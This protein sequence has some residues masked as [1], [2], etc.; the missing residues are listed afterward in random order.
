MIPSYLHPEGALGAKLE[1][2]RVGSSP[3]P[4]F[5]NPRQ[6]PPPPPDLP[7]SPGKADLSLGC[8]TIPG[9][10]APPHLE[11]QLPTHQGGSELFPP[12][13]PGP[14]NRGRAEGAAAVCSGDRL[15][16]RRA[17]GLCRGWWGQDPCFTHLHG[18]LGPCGWCEVWGILG[19]QF[20][21]SNFGRNSRRSGD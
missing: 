13:L 1:G 15:G 8:N 21:L 3:P 2:G 7:T 6:H 5:S 17:P 9:L 16:H 19:I 11:P 10:G 12:S 20:T 14:N 18:D 4:R